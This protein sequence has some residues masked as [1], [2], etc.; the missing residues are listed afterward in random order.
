MK[1]TKLLMALCFI[2]FLLPA[3][4]GDGDDVGG[5]D[6]NHEGHGHDDHGDDHHGHDHDPNEV[7]TTVKLNFAPESGGEAVEFTWADPEN[8]GEPVIDP[9]N[10]TEGETY[11]VS[12]RVLNE[13]EDPAED[14]TIELRDE[15]DEHQFFFTGDAVSS[16]ANENESAIITQAYADEDGNGFPVGLTNTIVATASG[17]GTLTIMLRH[18]PPVNGE[19][20]KTGTLADL[21]KNGDVA[22]LPGSVDIEINFDV[23][24]E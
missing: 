2:M 5:D 19:A 17:T 10:L 8:D 24:V 13:L 16:P 12:V 7:M 4:G 11:T 9:I 15:L 3:C 21:V 22:S 20:V 18:M 23:T 6:H 1:I 14:V